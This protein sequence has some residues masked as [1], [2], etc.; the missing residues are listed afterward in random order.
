[1]EYFNKIDTYKDDDPRS[2]SHWVKMV[3]APILYTQ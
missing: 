3:S 1:M 2:V